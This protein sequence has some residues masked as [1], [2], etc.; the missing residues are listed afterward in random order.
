MS[1]GTRLTNLWCLIPVEIAWVCGWQKVFLL[2]WCPL[3]ATLPAASD[4]SALIRH[5]GPAAHQDCLPTFALLKSFRPLGCLWGRSGGAKAPQTG[6]GLLLLLS[7]S[8]P[9]LLGWQPRV[10]HHTLL[11]VR[12]KD[13]SRLSEFEQFQVIFQLFLYRLILIHF[14]MLFF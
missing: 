2:S 9:P 3:L 1:W 5:L 13:L 11:L 7:P 4:C 6:E 14:N 8:F 10:R 12:E